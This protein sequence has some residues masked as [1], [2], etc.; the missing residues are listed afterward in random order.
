MIRVL[1]L[2]RDVG[3]EAGR[4]RWAFA[5]AL[6]QAKGQCPVREA[7]QKCGPC[8]LRE[9]EEFVAR[10]QEAEAAAL[11]QHVESMAR[12]RAARRPRAAA[13]RGRGRVSSS[14][15]RSVTIAAAGL[16]KAAVWS[17]PEARAAFN[18]QLHRVD[19]RRVSCVCVGPTC[20]CSASDPRSNGGRHGAGQHLDVS[21]SR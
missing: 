1:R 4:N 10:Q 14:A 8:L 11:R 19:P 3:G 18:R 5:A 13:S 9:S 21:G 15:P 6:H 16:T 2:I 20:S 12:L 17:D 7:G